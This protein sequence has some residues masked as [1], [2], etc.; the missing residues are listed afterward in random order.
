[1]LT[2]EL[3]RCS[4][5]ASDYAVSLFLSFLSLFTGESE[6]KRGY[7][8]ARKTLESSAENL[9]V[10]QVAASYGITVSHFIRSFKSEYGMTPN[11]Y[12]L[13][14]RISKAV[15]LL[16]MTDLSVQD[17]AYQCGFDDPFYFSR[18]FKK[19]VGITP[20]KYRGQI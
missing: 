8:E 9:T 18:I 7:E 10:E 12:R 16:R 13:N 11:E 15:S 19:R 20:S 17:I 3:I 6:Q 2:E 14:Y 4:D 1:M 5:E